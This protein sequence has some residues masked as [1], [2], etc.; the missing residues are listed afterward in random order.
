MALTG[1]MSP[2]STVVDDEELVSVIVPVRNGAP[3]LQ[4][5]LDGLLSQSYQNI[6]VL[7]SDNA[8]TDETPAICEAALRRDGRVKYVRHRE[9]LTAVENFRYWVAGARGRFILYAAHDDL[10]NRDFIRSLLFGLRDHSE[11]VC[12]IPSVSSFSR[13]TEHPFEVADPVP[14]PDPPTSTIQTSGFER[15]RAALRTGFPCY[16]LLRRDVMQDYPWID[17]DYAPDLPLVVYLY[18]AGDV[19]AA[20]GAT[21]YYWVPESPKSAAERA[22]AN[23]LRQLAP[24]PEVRAA[25]AAARMASLAR[26]RGGRSFPAIAG[27]VFIYASRRWPYAK[28]ALFAI[29]PQPL[30]SFWR[31]IKASQ[32]WR[33]N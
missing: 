12:V 33:L 4:L 21:L 23:A 18:L 14:W 6:E 13:Y 9:P 29:T 11:A 31:W 1:P 25:W 15:L 2:P 22:V 28:Q 32:G 8:S 24:F 3:T 19:V 7:I 5:V 10:R 26:A 20:E 17:L 30:R 16:G 27:F